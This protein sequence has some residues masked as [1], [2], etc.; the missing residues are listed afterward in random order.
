MYKRQMTVSFFPIGNNITIEAYDKLDNDFR[1][2]I[3]SSFESRLKTLKKDSLTLKL[4]HLNGSEMRIGNRQRLYTFYELDSPTEIEKK[5]VSL[6]DH[7][8]FSSSYSLEKFKT[9]GLTNC[10]FVPPGFDPDFTETNKTYLPDKIHFGLMGKWEKRKH[11]CEIIKAWAKKYGD[12]YKYQLT[13]CITNPFF[14]PEQ[15]NQVISHCLEGRR[16]GNIN[17]LPYLGTNSEVNDFLNSIDIDLTGLSGAE[18]WNLPSFNAT[19]LGKWSIVLNC[20]AHCDWATK[21]N[22]IL[23]DPEG[24]EGSVDGVFFKEGDL[25]NQGNIYSINQD[26]IIEKMVEAEGKV[27]TRNNEGVKLKEKFTYSKTLDGLLSKITV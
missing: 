10:S 24:V 4:W 12:N 9:L 19:C 17:F 16:Y 27:G 26:T 7:V 15:M 5:L 11:T 3:H 8:Y 14:K 18:G 20:T 2:W 6:Q 1:A 21:S 13:C 25:F 22:C 23:V